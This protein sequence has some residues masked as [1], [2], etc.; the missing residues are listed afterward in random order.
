[1]SAV[2]DVGLHPVLAAAGGH[3]VWVYN[4]N[5]ATI[6]EVDARTNRVLKTTMIAGFTPDR[7]CS[8][9]TGPVLGADASGAGSSTD[10]CTTSLGSRTCRPVG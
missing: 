8:L 7:C 10:A 2:I 6:S 9:F 3:S 4:K 1:V 5:T